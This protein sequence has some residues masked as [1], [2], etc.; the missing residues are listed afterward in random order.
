MGYTHDYR[1]EKGIPEP[2]G[3]VCIRGPGVFLGYYK[4]PERTR[5]VLD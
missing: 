1:D 2:R 5:K 4:D 3:E